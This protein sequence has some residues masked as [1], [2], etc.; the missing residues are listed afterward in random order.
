MALILLR[1][2]RPAAPPGLCYGRAD[3][4][5]ADSFEAE[6]RAVL[7][8]APPADAVISSPLRRCLTLARRI[9]AARGQEVR[10]DERVREMDF[11]TWE[12]R[13]WADIPREELDA[14]AAD[15]LNARPHGGESVAMLR[16][17]TRAALAEHG[18]GGGARL[19]VT[20]AGVIKAALARGSEAS[21][22][23]IAVAFGGWTALSPD[24]DRSAP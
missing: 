18:A 22:Y 8:A 4:D 15:F 12:G 21:D 7:K 19:I 5:L 23:D 3:L 20:H 24:D 9:A 1:H 14:W 13:L 11:G 17:R 10:V 2:T 6:A 16:E